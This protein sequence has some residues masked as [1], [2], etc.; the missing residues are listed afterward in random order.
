MT[1]MAGPE[2][3]KVVAVDRG[4]WATTVRAV[5]ALWAK[6]VTAVETVGEHL[7][8]FGQSMFWLFRRPF[9][10]AEL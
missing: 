4:A 7:V 5:D 2:D 1:L 6:P 9:R 8:L 10:P 3:T